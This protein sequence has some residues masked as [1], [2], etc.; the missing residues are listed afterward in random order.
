MMDGLQG[1]L[2]C[3]NWAGGKQLSAPNGPVTN[4]V[5]LR[6]SYLSILVPRKAPGVGYFQPST[7]RSSYEFGGSTGQ[8]CVHCSEFL[9]AASGASAWRGAIGRGLRPE[10]GSQWPMPS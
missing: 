6:G 8:A 9:G 4:G 1:A 10:V 3:P 5:G 2:A 7:Q